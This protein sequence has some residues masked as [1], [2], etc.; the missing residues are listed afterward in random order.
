MH[1][2]YSILSYASVVKLV[3][4]RGRTVYSKQ[5]FCIVAREWQNTI[6]FCERFV[7]MGSHFE[8]RLRDFMLLRLGCSLR[9]LPHKLTSKMQM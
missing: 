8:Y 6:R 1:A 2:M 3:G 7:N 4:A 5:S 9:I